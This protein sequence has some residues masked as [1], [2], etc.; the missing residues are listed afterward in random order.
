M[1]EL[2]PRRTWP[3]LLPLFRLD[4]VFVSGDLEVQSFE[5]PSDNLTRVASDHLPVVVDLWEHAA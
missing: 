2:R 5:V 4:H 1:P 3:A